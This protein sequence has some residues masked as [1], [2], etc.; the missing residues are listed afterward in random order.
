MPDLLPQPPQLYAV[1]PSYD[2][3][4]EALAERR[5]ERNISCEALDDAARL[6]AGYSSKALGPSQSAR[7]GWKSLFK[8]VR[9]LGL[10][11]VLEVDEEAAAALDIAPRHDNQ[12]RA[13]NYARQ[14]STRVMS[15]VFKHI[16][17]RGAAKLNRKMTKQQRSKRARH[18]ANA[19]W[20]RLRKLRKGRPREERCRRV[21]AR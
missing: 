7:L 15:R 17:A 8:I 1:L 3:M 6:A 16:G 4:V 18:A 19:R 14:P 2:L 12:A 20:S 21:M 11:F 10:R 13:G 9:P 5:L